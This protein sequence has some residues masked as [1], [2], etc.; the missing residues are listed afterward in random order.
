MTGKRKE[1]ISLMK[2]NFDLYLLLLPALIYLIIFSYLPM[3]GIQLAFKRYIYSLGV[4]KSP[5]VGFDNFGRFFS[6]YYL[7]N[8]IANTVLIS[9]YSLLFGF[10]VPIIMALFLNHINSTTFKRTVQTVTYAPN[11]ISMVTI[12]GMVVLFL[13]PRTGSINIILKALG[14]EAI[15]FLANPKYFRTIY[16]SSGIWQSSGFGMILYLAA[17]SAVD[18]ELY[19]AS[20][21]DG[22]TKMQKLIHIDLPIIK[23]TI[24]IVFILSLGGLMNVGFEKA[25]LLQNS[26][27]ISVSEVISTYVYKVGLLEGDH[28]FSTAIGLF[29]TV[30]NFILLVIVNQTVKLFSE[31]TLW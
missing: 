18:P 27:N 3:G 14:L 19:E 2:R 6:S 13:N 12:V 25:Y 5:W 8:L 20:E 21:I 24:M 30:V 29:N 10:S 11:F 17:L 22:A 7:T 4:W 1:T 26:L 9:V 31:S 15:N 16:I 23:P 28:A